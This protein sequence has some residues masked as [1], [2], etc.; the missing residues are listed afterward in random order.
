MN[1]DLN[2]S[3]I[4]VDPNVIQ[5]D[6]TEDTESKDT[7][8]FDAMDLFGAQIGDVRFIPSDVLP[9]GWHPLD[10]SVLKAS[11][12]PEYAFKIGVSGEF[13]LPLA[14]TPNGYSFSVKLR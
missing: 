3:H 9:E 2:L 14:K 8:I 1:E 13:R 4:P 12:W 7:E 10:G 6:G 11:D 5:L